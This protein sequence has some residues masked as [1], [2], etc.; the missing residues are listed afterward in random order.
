ME[1]GEARNSRGFKVWKQIFGNDE[2]VTGECSTQHDSKQK[3]KKKRS[4]KK[5]KRRTFREGV[6]V[7]AAHLLMGAEGYNDDMDEETGT[8]AYT[9]SRPVGGHGKGYVDILHLDDTTR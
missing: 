3:S 5:K 6:M 8:M 9:F 7:A 2:V 1:C 4:K